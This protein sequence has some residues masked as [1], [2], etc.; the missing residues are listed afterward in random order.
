MRKVLSILL[1]GLLLCSSS[2]AVEYMS[3]DKGKTLLSYV[4]TNATG[5]YAATAISTSTIVP[6]TNRIIGYEIV[7]YNTGKSIEGFVGLYDDADT[8]QADNTYLF[9][10]SEVIGTYGSGMVIYPYPKELSYGLCIRQ[11][12]NTTVTIYYDRK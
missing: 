6:G 5:A 11:G 2:F 12:A 7:H 8:T 10:E 4:S 3:T 9:A 1:I